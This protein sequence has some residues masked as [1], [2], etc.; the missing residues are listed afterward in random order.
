MSL[1]IFLSF[2]V[3]L[4]LCVCVVFLSIFCVSRSLSGSNGAWKGLFIY[5]FVYI[6]EVAL[7]NFLSFFLSL[8][9]SLC[10]CCLSLYILCF[11]ESFRQQWSM[12]ERSVYLFFLC[13]Y[14]MCV[15]I[16]LSFFLSLCVF[17]CL[18]CLSLYI[19]CFH[20][21]FRQQWSMMERSI[22]LFISLYILYVCLY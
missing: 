12:M 16:N 9:V 22:Y 4:C 11:H 13:I 20:E 19:L 15:F 1:L 10:L 2:S 6:R 5:F 8:C 14:Y 21:S 18:C 3:F 17:L 7:L